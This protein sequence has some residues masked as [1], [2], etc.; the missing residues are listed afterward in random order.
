[1]TQVSGGDESLPWVE[2]STRPGV[3]S[4][5]AQPAPAPPP[6]PARPPLPEDLRPGAESR[7]LVDELSRI[8][9]DIGTLSAMPQRGKGEVLTHFHAVREEL[10]HAHLRTI[11][12]ERLKDA[13]EGRLR[14]GQIHSAGYVTVADVL[15]AGPSR[16]Q[17]LPGVGPQ[18]ATQAFAAARHLASTVE[19]TVPVRL[20]AERR[21]PS[22][23][24]L[25]A[26]LRSYEDV[27]RV[28]APL[29]E[30]LV[31]LAQYASPLLRQDVPVPGR[32][33]WMFTGAGRREQFRQHIRQID[34]LMRDAWVLGVVHRLRSGLAQI[35]ASRHD[36]T[37]LW[38]DYE[39][40]APDYYGLLGE[41][42]DLSLDVAAVHGHLPAELAE[43][44]AQQQLDQSQLTVSL[45]GYQAFG[46]KFALVQRRCIVGDE[47][48]LGKT[49][50]AIAVM[51]HLAAIGSTH[52]LVVCPASVLVNW[53][54]EVRSRS[55]LA[56]HRVHGAE[57]QHA[58]AAWQRRGGVAVTTYETLR[59]LP[60]PE[61]RPALVV[62][63]EAHFIKNPSAARSK[64]TRDWTDQADRVLFLTGTAM[65]NRVDE[66]RN[67]VGY[68][69]PAVAAS[70]KNVTGIAGAAFF[71][72]AVASVYLR[73]NQ[74]DVLSE[75]PDRLDTLDWVD[76]TKYDVGA[77][78]QAVM[79]RNFMAMRRASFASGADSAK[80]QRLLEV[81]DE[82]AS[83]GWKV[84]VFSYFHDV[85]LA[86]QRALGGAVHGPLTGS[87]APAARQDLVDRFSSSPGHAVLI[88]QIQAGGTGL[89]MQA[90][91]VVIL[92]EPQ[93]KPSIEE[94][95]IGRCH[96][97][98]QVR[99]VHVHRL[100][101]QDS[102]D[103]RMLEILETKRVLFDE[104]VRRS[105]L[106]DIS[107]DAVDIAD[108]QATKLAVKQA[109]EDI[110]EREARRLG[111]ARHQP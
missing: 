5:P 38:R 73:R 7:A 95:A 4:A 71:R 41:L 90:A 110:I 44:I 51:A 83:N 15:N 37:E 78:R 39:A 61:H 93:W 1:M 2:S 35:A 70:I 54:R 14:L 22:H 80:V 29:R 19:Q 30:D 99:R 67:L 100:L 6:A 58:Y 102:V 45:R 11:G 40:R 20:D 28:F 91:S 79:S 36:A 17:T 56:P 92:A 103:Q 46:A 25:L 88:S 8:L 98:G 106:K 82:A 109:E 31:R 72:T 12:V 48:G 3:R 13:T 75:L 66:F 52:F 101:A 18:T 59:S 21:P 50:E 63:D 43:R 53:T 49:V 27:D 47:M 69:Q 108:T 10:V 89:N 57:R 96:R 81:V 42:A 26:A 105:A 74:E 68:L 84:V 34:A 23:T 111:I 76:L 94:Q 65:E 85:L 16:L 60:A 77:Y 86:V 62:V 33:R 104:Y 55:T 97:M 87:V 24:Q 9:A 64:A 32:L 107:P